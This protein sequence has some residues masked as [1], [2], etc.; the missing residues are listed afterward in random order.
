MFV[1][2][3]SGCIMPQLDTQKVPQAGQALE[4]MVS[5]EQIVS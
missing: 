2:G 4:C 5:A 3:D 1:E